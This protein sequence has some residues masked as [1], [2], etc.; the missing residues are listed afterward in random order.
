MFYFGILIGIIFSVLLFWL[1][2]WRGRPV[3]FSSL[4]HQKLGRDGEDLNPLLNQLSRDLQ[5]LREAVVSLEERLAANELLPP[6]HHEIPQDSSRG[7]EIRRK[8]YEYRRRGM[9]LDEIAKEIGIGKGELQLA[10]AFR[11]RGKEEGRDK[12]A[13]FIYSVNSAKRGAGEVGGYE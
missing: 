4:L 12:H 11:A 13:R 2:A 7:E 1:A 9:A 5:C 8:V 3:S 10:L 6:V